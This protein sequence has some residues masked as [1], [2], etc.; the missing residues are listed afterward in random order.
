MFYMIRNF[1]ETGPWN[2]AWI[3]SCQRD[4]HLFYRKLLFVTPRKVTIECNVHCK[5]HFV[6]KLILM[7]SNDSWQNSIL[8]WCLVSLCAIILEHNQLGRIH[9]KHKIKIILS[10]KKKRIKSSI[11]IFTSRFFYSEAHIFSQSISLNQYVPVRLS[12]CVSF[13]SS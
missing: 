9:H 6:R 13:R 3:T 7:S 10:K 8:F 4:C 5:R 11:F 1:P 12:V 2:V